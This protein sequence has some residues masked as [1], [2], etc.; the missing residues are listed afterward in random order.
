MQPARPSANVPPTKGG[1]WKFDMRGPSLSM[2]TCSCLFSPPTSF[3]LAQVETRWTHN[4]TAGRHQLWTLLGYWPSRTDRWITNATV[5]GQHR[6]L[7]CQ[8]LYSVFAAGQS[9]GTFLPSCDSNHRLLSRPRFVVLFFSFVET[10]VL[11]V[12]A[13]VDNE[14]IYANKCTN[15]S[16]IGRAEELIFLFFF[17]VFISYYSEGARLWPDSQLTQ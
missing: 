2:L 11:Q 14:K 3:L 10:P 17:V 9:T 5:Q 7:A 8:T 13:T 15:V 12:S 16:S 4:T 6:S 1:R